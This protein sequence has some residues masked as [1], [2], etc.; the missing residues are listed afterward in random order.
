MLLRSTT[1]FICNNLLYGL[2]IS[3][4]IY[5]TSSKKHSLSISRL[6]VLHFINKK[7]KYFFF[8]YCRYE[9]LRS[10]DG[11][12]DGLRVIKAILQFSS[13]LLGPRKSCFLEVHNRHVPMIKSWLDQNFQ[14]NLV[15]SGT[16]KD[17]SGYEI[18][19]RITKVK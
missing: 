10:L 15:V 12:S 5:L 19:I 14:L 8:T 1:A 16:F 9:D 6:H 4:L 18:F 17:F 7:C 2:Y 11:G 3:E 13:K